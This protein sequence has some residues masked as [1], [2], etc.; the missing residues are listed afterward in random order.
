MPVTSYRIDGYA[1]QLFAVDKKGGRTRWGDRMITLYS[2]G[3]N[4]GQAVFGPSSRG[5]PEPF[6][7]DGRIHFFAD[8]DQYHAVVDLLRADKPVYIAWKPIHDPKENPAIQHARESG[9]KLCTQSSA[10]AASD[11]SPWPWS[12][13]P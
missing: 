12:N 11:S 2:S 5:I 8:S 9:L 1:V 6:M 10:A 4:I 7:K 3:R 13:S